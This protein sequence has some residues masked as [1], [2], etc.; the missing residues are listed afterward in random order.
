MYKLYHCIG[1]D[2]HELH[3]GIAITFIS[4]NNDVQCRQGITFRPNALPHEVAKGLE[5]FADWI[6]RKFN[7]EGELV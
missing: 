2:E 4:S 6:Y 3:K 7:Y 5:Q 1:S